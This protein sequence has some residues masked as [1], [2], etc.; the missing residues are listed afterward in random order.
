MTSATS[1]TA[2]ARDE[3]A[4]LRSLRVSYDDW[5]PHFR[6]S[7]SAALEFLRQQGPHGSDFNASAAG[8]FDKEGMMTANAA[9]EQ[10][11]RALEAWAAYADAGLAASLPYAA[12]ARVDAA[13]DLMEQVQTLLDDT[14]V[15]PA[16]PVVLA[17][18]ALE[19]LLRGLVAVHAVQVKGKPGLATYATALRSAEALTVQDVKDVTAWAGQRNEAAHGDFDKLSRPR[20]QILVDGINLFM[21]QRTPTVDAGQGPLSG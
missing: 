20:A 18:A 6:S 9:F 11:A 13:T 5:A 8:A 4:Q 17:G 10:T 3:A 19:E 16:A 2:W 1:A 7:A 14:Q 21:R 15:H 12:R